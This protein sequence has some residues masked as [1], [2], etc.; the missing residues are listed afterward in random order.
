MGLEVFKSSPQQP[1]LRS[2][3][4]RINYQALVGFPI[5]LPKHRFTPRFVS[6]TC[7]T[8]LIFRADHFCHRRSETKINLVSTSKSRDPPLERSFGLRMSS[9]SC[10]AGVL[11]APVWLAYGCLDAGSPEVTLCITSHCIRG[12][13]HCGERFPP[14]LQASVPVQ[15]TPGSLFYSHAE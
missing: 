4:R 2:M 14:K 13:V 11:V 9:V 1:H 5:S 12:R 7:F 8:F 6:V 10:R 3:K 15:H